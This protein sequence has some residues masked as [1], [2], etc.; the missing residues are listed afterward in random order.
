MFDSERR[1]DSW[2][3]GHLLILY[4]NSPHHHRYPKE[5]RQGKASRINAIL[6]EWRDSWFLL[7][8]FAWELHERK[9]YASDF[10]T[11]RR[12]AY[13]SNDKWNPPS[14]RRFMQIA[15]Q[16]KLFL[17]M[18]FVLRFLC[19]IWGMLPT[20]SAVYCDLLQRHM[21]CHLLVQADSME[22]E[23]SIWSFKLWSR[24]VDL[25]VLVLYKIFVSNSWHCVWPWSGIGIA[26]EHDR[27][28]LSLD[29]ISCWF[30][31]IN[32]HNLCGVS[33]YM[34]CGNPLS[35]SVTP[36][37]LIVCFGTRK[38]LELIDRSSSS[39]TSRGQ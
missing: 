16:R 10:F 8:G 30:E 13:H 26:F 27:A 38:S 24:Q 37:Y 4:N 28:H 20:A 2:G 1:E 39:H 5:E 33:P 9:G 18:F 22:R 29:F 36:Q 32:Q 31:R 34:E 21:S 19:R 11:K 35:G 23:I 3:N 25:Q 15:K 7:A 17:R 14:R 12:R 6:R